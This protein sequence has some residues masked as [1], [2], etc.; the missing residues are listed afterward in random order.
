MRADDPNLPDSANGEDTNTNADVDQKELVIDQEKNNA[1]DFERLLNLDS[2]VPDH[3]D[4]R[5]RPS[6]NRIQEFGDRQHDMMANV[7]DR[8]ETLQEH[9]RDRMA[10]HM[11]PAQIV[12][13]DE[14]PRTPTGKPEKGRLASMS[15][16]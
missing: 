1:D 4:E 9:C 11:I 15:F 6:A 5:P 10:K 3:F 14:I 12:F 16:P 2:E 13:L 7:V 8:S